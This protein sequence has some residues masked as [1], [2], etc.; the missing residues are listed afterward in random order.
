MSFSRFLSVIA[1]SACAALPAHAGATLDKIKSS[2]VITIGNREASIP[3]SFLDK[4]NNPTG[5]SVDLCAAVVERLKKELSLPGLEVRYMTVAPAA[6]IPL[7]TNGTIDMECSTTSITLSRMQQVNFSSPTFA[8]AGRILTRTDSG[9]KDWA[10]LNGK[11]IGVAQG[12]N[13]EKAVKELAAKPEYSNMKVLTLKDQGVG[14]LSVETGR[15]DGFATDD[16][17]LYGLRSNS[18]MKDELVVTGTPLGFATFA[19]MIPRNDDDFRLVVN[20]AL[21]EIFGSGE[22]KALYQKWFA[23]LDLPMSEANAVIYE[24]GAIVK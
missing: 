12:T 23:P 13:N 11:T 16:V 4:D 24:T 5:Y 2:G 7:L 3:F 10:D 15:V 17:V 9:V 19:I 22:I 21:A 1:I 20:S 18:R 8:V 6:R 14:L